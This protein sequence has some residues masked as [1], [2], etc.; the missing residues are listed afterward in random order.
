MAAM[1]ATAPDKKAS[2]SDAPD[3]QS[4]AS[5]ADRPA[6]PGVGVRARGGYR[7]SINAGGLENIPAGVFSGEE[8]APLSSP[9]DGPGDPVSVQTGP[10]PDNQNGQTGNAP[11]R[12]AADSGAANGPSAPAQG[13][14]TNATSPRPD[15]DAAPAQ[16]QANATLI[17]YTDEK[18]NPVEPPPTYAN[19]HPKIIEHMKAS[20]FDQALAL[21]DLLLEK[22]TLN[23]E[24]YEDVLHIR[25][26]SLFALYKDDIPNHFTE[27]AD[28]AQ[29]AL[30]Y[31][32]E[33]R[34]NSAELLRLGYM[35]LH[36]NNLPA[37]EA[38]FRL[39]RTRFP[40]GDNVA[41]S[42]YY[43]GDYYYGRSELQKAADQFQHLIQTFPNSRYTRESALGL[44]RS[45]Y[46]MGYY[47][48]AYNVVDYIQR[49]WGHFYIEYPPF[50][51]MMG[52][53]AFRLGKREEA[54]NDY[55]LYINLE[56]QGDEADIILTRIGDI[57]SL[58]REKKSADAIYLESAGRYP[59]REGG[60]VAMMRM[61]EEGIN[62]NP[63]IAGMFSIFAGPFKLGPQEV[64]RNI[65]EKHPESS[66]AP[67][68]KVKLALWHLW[69]KDYHAA[70]DTLTKFV[71]EHPNHELAPRAREIAI[72]TFAVLAAEGMQDE[73]YKRMLD[74]WERYAIVHREPADLSPES[75][76][77]LAVSYRQQGNPDA[78]L[79]MLEPFF[80][81]N[82][83]PD[84]SEMALGL[85][86]GI[87]LEYDQWPSIR[88]V[89]RRVEGSNMS[90]AS[91]Q[92]LDYAQALA[93]ENLNEP[94]T[95]APIWQ[96]L[97]DSGNLPPAQHAY[98]AYF[99]AM[100]AERDRHL[101]KA[102]HL[103]LEA[104]GGLRALAERSANPAD[105]AKIRTQLSSLLDVTENAGRLNEALNFA[106][107]YLQALP[108][109]DP[110]RMGVRYRMARIYKNQ[111]DT[112]NWKS[113]LGEIATQAPDSVYGK[114]AASELKAASI[115]EDAARYS[116]TGRI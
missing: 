2:S 7:G 108:E 76:I 44:A 72:Q 95:A 83:I 35:N 56:P 19:L 30:S 74:I 20:E 80:L 52:D 61:A 55:W 106:R 65:I 11:A 66:L 37:A 64:Y 49:R 29:R 25:S 42:Y 110:E 71:E 67:L 33:S 3:A 43:Q 63:T 96:R 14:Q 48:Q 105:L 73:R 41:L 113:I 15:P 100:G 53:V 104:L 97:Y 21:A 47:D 77:S 58:Q 68:A 84:Y 98:A 31:N 24:Q 99:L 94:D 40:D 39:L 81:G 69:N 88:E 57:Y 27:I 78:A 116:P 92:Q 87:Y 109:N 34:R 59:D 115:A 101:E 9:K 60:L 54:L 36:L 90:A 6:P 89:A 86:I 75:R 102:Y 45:F 112:D 26:E 12:A 28:A 103:G 23:P 1:P 51:N 22:A 32:P 50:L 70:L 16:N 13:G 85:V 114:I 38:N 4:A 5:R 17:I 79:R 107:Q 93:A 111:G 8:G 18:G 91:R 10:D 46:R 62:D 82:W